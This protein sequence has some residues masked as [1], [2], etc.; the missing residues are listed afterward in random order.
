MFSALLNNFQRRSEQSK[1]CTTFST[2][3]EVSSLLPARLSSSM[4][5]SHAA[6]S[7]LAI[8]LSQFFSLTPV[9]STI[10]SSQN[11]FSCSQEDI[12]LTL[13]Q[14]FPIYQITETHNTCTVGCE[15]TNPT[16]LL[17]IPHSSSSLSLCADHRH[18][19]NGPS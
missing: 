16:V 8:S 2:C 12:S 10:F 9:N 1:L 15:K 6:G 4:A 7:L 17:F 18:P 13:L 5:C 3:L 19:A 14:L 11:I